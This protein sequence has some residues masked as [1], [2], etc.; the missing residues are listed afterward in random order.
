V[1]PKLIIESAKAEFEAAGGVVLEQTALKGITVHSD[2]AEVN[3]F[4]ASN[5]DPKT[6]TT[7]LVLD[8]MG[9]FS[10]VVKQIREG[11]TPDGVCLV[12]GTCARGYR[13]EDNTSS[14]V[15]Y[16]ERPISD[17]QQ[18][19]WEAFPAGSGPNDRTTYMFTYIDANQD[20]PSLASFLETYWDILPEYQ[21]VKLEDL[22]FLR[23]LF[24]F[25]PTYRDS[26]LVPPFPRVLQVG[27]ASGI[28]SPLSFG[29]FG[30]L[31]RHLG[32]LSD[33]VTEAVEAEALDATSLGYINAYSPGLSSAWLFQK[34][35]SVPV[36]GRP[37]PSLIN[38]ILGSNFEVMDKL[39][40][41]VL[42]PFLQDVVQFGP[43]AQA[44]A[45]MT[46]TRPLLVPRIIASTGVLPVLDWTRHFIALGMYDVL[47][48]ISNPLKPLVEKI[49]DKSERFYWKRLLEAWEY[50]SGNDYK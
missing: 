26:P 49:P 43:L 41:K 8:C 37:A 42:R 6:I 45:G 35:M 44:M 4:A 48:K 36:G 27:D 50:G 39:G 12:V 34:A 22:E 9:N 46:V 33:A 3:V 2:A 32:R 29:G 31:S 1:S 28:Q 18:I 5:A 47:F 10:P 30:A 21:N 23:C 38:E 13:T 40:G 17:Y 25:F 16:T 24:G 14:D 7:N 11:Q 19:F 20:R 15:I